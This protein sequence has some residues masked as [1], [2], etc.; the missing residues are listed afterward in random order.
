MP[1]MLRKRRRRV[2]QDV[3][4]EDA[5]NI[6]ILT[7]AQREAI[8]NDLPANGELRKVCAFAH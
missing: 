8:N 7:E 5:E 4:D 1:S 3:N 2:I 6:P